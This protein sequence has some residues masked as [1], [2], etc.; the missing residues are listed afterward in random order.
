MST[1]LCCRSEG[2]VRVGALGVESGEQYAREVV[3]FEA[4]LNN[5]APLR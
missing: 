4:A 2:D 1:L 5:G 3:L